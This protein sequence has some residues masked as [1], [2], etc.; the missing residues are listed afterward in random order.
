MG[1]SAVCSWLAVI[2]PASR[3]ASSEVPDG[4]AGEMWISGAGV[5]AGYLHRDDL[6]AERFVT[7]DGL[8]CYRTGDLARRLP[9]GELEFLGRADRQVKVRGFRIEPGEIEAVLRGCAGIRD[10]VVEVVTAGDGT[11]FLVAYVVAEDERLGVA[12]RVRPARSRCPRTWC[13]TRS[14]CCRRS[15]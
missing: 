15:R 5:C 13:P 4:A 2:T 9:D 3:A 12:R 14:R 8:R 6:T 7:V 11:A 10:A 1:C